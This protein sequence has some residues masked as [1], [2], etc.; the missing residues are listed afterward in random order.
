MLTRT[1]WR[2]CIDRFDEEPT[3]RVDNLLEELKL[4]PRLRATLHRLNNVAATLAVSL[5]VM[6][7]MCA[8][9][10]HACACAQWPLNASA[11]LRSNLAISAGLILRFYSAG[12][13]CAPRLASKLVSLVTAYAPPPAA[14]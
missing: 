7:L 4:Y 14:L 9:S 1:W 13:T 5:M 3:L 10:P 6:V 11:L 2:R 12:K 8:H